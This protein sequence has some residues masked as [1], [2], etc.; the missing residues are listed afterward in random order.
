[1]ASI[2]QEIIN[3]VTAKLQSITYANSY[4]RE[5]GSGRV[6]NANKLPQQI[7]TPAIIFLQGQENADNSVGDRYECSIALSIAFIDAYSGSDPD[8]EANEFLA[9]IQKAMSGAELTI[10]TTNYS[11][12]AAVTTFAQILERGST[13]NAGDPVRGRIY[14]EVHYN[15]QYQRSIFDP[16]K[17]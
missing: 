17:Q 1:M 16:S 3:A 13:L 7:P 12:G 10:T 8:T 9:D 15:V 11:T 2:R 5:I 4:N 14:G 6:Y